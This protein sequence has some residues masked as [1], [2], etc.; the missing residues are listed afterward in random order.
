MLRLDFSPCKYFLC[1]KSLTV[2]TLIVLFFLFTQDINRNLDILQ[3]K[4]VASFYL[5]VFLLYREYIALV[6]G[7]SS[8]HF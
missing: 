6:P 4:T 1:N 5:F 7:R 3:L 8:T 2:Y